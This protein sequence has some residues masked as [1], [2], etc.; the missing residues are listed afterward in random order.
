MSRGAQA[1]GNGKAASTRRIPAAI[2][3]VGAD[4][5]ADGGCDYGSRMEWQVT[6]PDDDALKSV[7]AY[8]AAGEARR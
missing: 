7:F 2:Q 6:C 5:A 4:V 8:T 3:L 1:R